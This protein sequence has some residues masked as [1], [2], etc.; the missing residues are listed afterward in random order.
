MVIDIGK[1][2]ILPCLFS[3]WAATAKGSEH[4]NHWSSRKFRDRRC[5]CIM[6]PFSDFASEHFSLNVH[7]AQ[8]FTSCSAP[9]YYNCFSLDLSCFREMENSSMNFRY[10]KNQGSS[11]SSPTRKST[12]PRSTCPLSKQIQN[13][14]LAFIVSMYRQG[15]F[16]D[17]DILLV[18]GCHAM[19]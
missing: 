3:F 12:D 14:D 18:Y 5:V 10:G 6:Q 19:P 13:R 9:R 4:L 1:L 15:R 16:P 11:L 8:E 2:F 17:Q 7:K